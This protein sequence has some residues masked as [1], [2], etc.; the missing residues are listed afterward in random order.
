MEYRVVKTSVG[1]V[2]QCSKGQGHD[3][4][5]LLITDEGF[6]LVEDPIQQAEFCPLGTEKDAL[7]LIEDYQLLLEDA[8]LLK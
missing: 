1:F 2:A 7:G 4:K 8:K 5:G 6:E 3:W